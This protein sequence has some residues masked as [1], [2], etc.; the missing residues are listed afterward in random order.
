MVIV[1]LLIGL[2]LGAGLSFGTTYLL[3]AVLLG[4]ASPIALIVSL[5]AAAGCGAYGAIALANNVYEVSFLSILGFFLDMT[6]SIPNTVFGLIY[7][8]ICLIA[9][10]GMEN[11]SDTQR[12]GT[13]CY[14]A[15]PRGAGW[16]MTVGPVIGGGWSR[17]EEVHVWQG[18]IFGPI[19][20]PV[21]FLCYFFIFLFRL[22]LGKVS[23]IAVEAYRRICFEDWAYSSGGDSEISWGMWFLWLLISSGFIALSVLAVYG[24]ATHALVIALIALGLMVAYS[25]VRN[26]TPAYDL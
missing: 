20:Y 4:V 9:G 22:I 21:Y 24:F 1:R 19:Y 5:V 10:G 25:I 23:D 17:H 2:V 18:R 8:P 26:L 12:S 7:V 13:L 3:L 15:S 11:S 6:W 14:T 16:R